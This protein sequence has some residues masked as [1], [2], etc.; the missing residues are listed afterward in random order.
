MAK[1]KYQK[2]PTPNKV[3]EGKI[4]SN[5]LRVMQNAMKKKQEIEQKNKNIQRETNYRTSVRQE[6][7]L[8]APLDQA[9]IL[10]DKIKLMDFN[11]IGY[12]VSAIRV[13][14]YKWDE[15]KINQ[16]VAFAKNDTVLE[17]RIRE[18]N[19]QLMEIDNTVKERA[20]TL[21]SELETENK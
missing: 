9:S 2:A 20:I 12:Y 16:I 13:C 3:A 8:N 10:W 19:E 4:A 11:E 6:F 21:K 17:D 15:D 14:E 5:N 1:K 18:D 7:T